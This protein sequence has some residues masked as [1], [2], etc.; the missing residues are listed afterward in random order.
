LL[1]VFIAFFPDAHPC[2]TGDVIGRMNPALVLGQRDEGGI[3][4]VGSKSGGIVERHAGVITEF[5]AEEAVGPVFLEDG[6]VVPYAGEVDL[7]ESGTRY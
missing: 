3:P 6:E 5:G 7:A 4:G 2:K 1:R